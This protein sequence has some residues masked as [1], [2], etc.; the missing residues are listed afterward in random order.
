MK[1]FYHYLATAAI[2][3]ATLSASAQTPE[4]LCYGYCGDNF[5]GIGI[6]DP[7]DEY[8]IAAAFQLTESDVAQFDGC[9]ITGV[10][11]AFSTGRNKEITIFMTEDL[12]GTPFFEQGG[13]VRAG[14]WNDIHVTGAPKIE[15]G[16]PIYIG[17]RH[18]VQNPLAMPV[19]FDEN[20]TGYSDNADYMSYAWNEEGLK[21]E[22]KHYGSQFGNAG[23]RVY[24][25]GDKFSSSNCIPMDVLVP[26]FSHPGEDFEFAVSF[27]NA[28]TSVVTDIEIE[29]QI[30]E[31]D[32]EISTFSSLSVAPNSRGEVR[33]TG[34][35]EEDSFKLPVKARITKVNGEANSSAERWV[36]STFAN[37]NGLFMRKVVSEKLTGQNCGY[38]PRAIVAYDY[39][40]EQVGDRFIGIEVHNYTSAERLYASSYSPMLNHY[41]LV[42][43]G[44][45]SLMVNRDVTNGAGTE[46]GSLYAAFEK[47]FTDACQYGITA[48]F[49]ES[50]KADC[51]DVTAT[52][53]SA[54][55]V[56]NAN[57]AV[58]FVITEDGLAGQQFNGYNSGP[59]LPE[60]LGKGSIVPWTYDCVARYIHPDWDGIDGSVPATLEGG[61]QYSY[62]VE[63][64]SLGNT[65]IKK[66]ANVV[67]LLIDKSTGSILNADLVHIDPTRTYNYPDWEKQL[68]EVREVAEVLPYTVRVENG[69]IYLMGE[70]EARVYTADGLCAGIISEGN[71]LQLTPGFYLVAGA[72][73]TQKIFV[74]QN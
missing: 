46:K 22:W 20:D 15:K 68:T 7:P 5:T 54:F 57:F 48:T 25:K 55:D 51:L 28:S 72:E 61:K 74:S 21:S 16:K 40:R 69:S 32:P 26:D 41:K 14:S 43:S 31:A 27:T 38:C 44:A 58:T 12:S 13:R 56:N 30:G 66:N 62:T 17:Y 47:E 10:S 9:E 19:G 8:W 64:M 35:S 24:L 70:G 65:L 52:V 4:G 53:T 63:G 23:I 45:P 60:W 73:K 59:G 11:I 2:A 1:R 67:A 42:F 50:A 18:Q 6:P 71:P 34:N 33:L 39:V 3:V 49:K 36:L 37:T 29:Y